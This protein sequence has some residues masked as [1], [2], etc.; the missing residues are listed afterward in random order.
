MRTHR[1]YIAGLLTIA[2]A[3]GAE[4]AAASVCAAEKMQP[5]TVTTLCVINDARARHEA[6]RLRLDPKL[7]QAARAHARDMVA[8]RY[9]SHTSR[10][11][12]SSSARIARTG[13]MRGRRRWTVGENIAWRTG[14]PDPRAIVRRWLRSR[15]HRHVLLGRRYRVLGIGIAGGTPY[16]AAGATY[17]ADFGS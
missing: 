4:P 17:T 14:R 7:A 1:F 13:W 2:A 3:L 8:H 12:L 15:P 16:G 9:F 6:P 11:G 5:L 10:Q